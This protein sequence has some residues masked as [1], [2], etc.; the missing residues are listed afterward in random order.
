MG[1]NGQPSVGSIEKTTIV[2]Y[3]FTVHCPRLHPLFS[4]NLGMINNENF[5]ICNE[6]VFQTAPNFSLLKS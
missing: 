4:N 1:N 2:D 5:A 3:Y 6:C